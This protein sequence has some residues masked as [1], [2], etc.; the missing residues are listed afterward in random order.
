[1]RR[2]ARQKV[3]ILSF[4]DAEDTARYVRLTGLHLGVSRLV[5]AVPGVIGLRSGAVRGFGPVRRTIVEAVLR[6]LL[7]EYFVKKHSR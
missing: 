4:N 7:I 6:S 2:C 1:M 3:H 5:G